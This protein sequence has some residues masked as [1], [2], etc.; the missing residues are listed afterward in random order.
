MIFSEPVKVHTLTKRRNDFR[1]RAEPIVEVFSEFAP[2]DF[3]G[4]IT[5]GA[6]DQPEVGG[7]GPGSP[8]TWT[9]VF[10]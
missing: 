3:L 4:K 1:K 8:P 5:V 2:L 9:N 10:S 7:N 6:R